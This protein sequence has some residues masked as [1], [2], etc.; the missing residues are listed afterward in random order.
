G[1]DEELDEEL[2]FH[3]EAEM[4]ANVRRGMTLEQARA[5]ARRSF[6]GVQQTKEAYRDR[7]GIPWIDSLLADVR[8][9]LR[10]MRQ[11]PGFTTI[12]VLTLALGIGATSSIFSVVNAILLKP[13][14][15]RASERLVLVRMQIPK[16]GT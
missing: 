15:F 1:L 7:R 16:F 9:G 2:R 12:A 14:P 6:G 10:V 5:E 3:L 13:L 4:D 11:S 8:Y